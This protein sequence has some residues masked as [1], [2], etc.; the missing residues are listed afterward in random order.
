MQPWYQH[1]RGDFKAILVYTVR[2]SISSP[3]ENKIPITVH[4]KWPA[5]NT[6]DSF[7]LLEAFT[8]WS[9]PDTGSLCFSSHVQSAVHFQQIRQRTVRRSQKPLAA[10]ESTGAVGWGKLANAHPN[11]EAVNGAALPFSVNEQKKR[12]ELYNN[13]LVGSL[14]LWS[15]WCFYL[16]GLMHRS[17]SWGSRPPVPVHRPLHR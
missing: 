9:G 15:F 17:A 2:P 10:M 11:G 4:R 13:L 16:S 14:G 8:L 3:K 5:K 6:K 12:P 1:S 7:F